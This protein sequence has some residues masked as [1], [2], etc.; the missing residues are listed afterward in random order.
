V[1]GPSDFDAAR[2]NRS[3]AV[4]RETFCRPY[5]PHLHRGLLAV[6]DSGDNCVMIWD[7][8]PTLDV[9]PVDAPPTSAGGHL[10]G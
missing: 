4:T 1:I 6:A 3:R 5:G 9:G 10:G 8:G 7:C 2:E